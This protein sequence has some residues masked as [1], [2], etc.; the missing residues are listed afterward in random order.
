MLRNLLNSKKRPAY[1]PAIL[2][3]FLTLLPVTAFAQLE[4]SER[5][6]LKTLLLKA[7]D[8]NTAL[9]SR[10]HCYTEKDAGFQ[11][12]SSQLQ[13]QAGDLHQQENQLSS[14]LQRV[15]S[16]AEGF[17]QQLQLAR[18]QLAQLQA[19][20]QQVEW[21]IRSRQAELDS[22][23]AYW[24]FVGFLC[25]LAGEITGLN[26]QLRQLS[27]EQQGHELTTR[28]LEPH[29]LA[30]QNRQIL[31]EQ[32]WHEA[33]SKL[34][35]TQAAMVATEAK[36]KV[37]KASLEEIRA[38]RQ[39]YATQQDSL[40]LSFTEFENLDPASDRRSVTRRL[41]QESVALNDLLLK[42]H[43]LL[44]KNGLSLPGGEHICAL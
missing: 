10:L 15:K 39:Q 11:T 44:D 1:L 43:T 29:F 40:N 25:D 31:A 33:Q 41:R 3:L 36:I 37:L 27:A 7:R 32:R 35:Q 5:E 4:P 18:E 30:A 26:G 17:R 14:E 16:E 28:T 38:L 23:K 2:L 42:A 6:E 19:R 22:C 21:E 24:G 20:M 9:Q 8:V 12:Q 34:G 13:Q